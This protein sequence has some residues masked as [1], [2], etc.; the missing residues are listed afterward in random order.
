MD[1]MYVW[2][3]AISVWNKH[4][5]IPTMNEPASILLSLL[6]SLCIIGWSSPVRAGSIRRNIIVMNTTIAHMMVRSVME[7]NILRIGRSKSVSV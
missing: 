1:V 2:S 3:T 5:H 4:A 6:I 7:N